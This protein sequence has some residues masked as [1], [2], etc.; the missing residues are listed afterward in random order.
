MES[1]LSS[2]CYTLI[3]KIVVVVAIRNWQTSASSYLGI[4][5]NTYS[6]EL[7]QSPS[8]PTAAWFPAFS[9][10]GYKDSE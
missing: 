4:Q 3:D 9:R 8:T 1:L 10:G 6:I 5:E 7:M 2:V